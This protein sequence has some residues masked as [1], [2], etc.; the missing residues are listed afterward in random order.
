[1]DKSDSRRLEPKPVTIISINKTSIN[2]LIIYCNYSQGGLKY[3]SI[4][5][6]YRITIIIIR[7][8]SLRPSRD[9][10]TFL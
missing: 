9:I 1:M 8:K 6:I 7:F 5:L 3:K 10:T 2:P 4:Y